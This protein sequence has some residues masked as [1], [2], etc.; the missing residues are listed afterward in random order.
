MERT[1]CQ[2]AWMKMRNED[3]GVYQNCGLHDVL[4]LWRVGLEMIPRYTQ[5]SVRDWGRWS[6]SFLVMT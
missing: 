2:S 5:E 4:D 1:W 3:I 6:Y